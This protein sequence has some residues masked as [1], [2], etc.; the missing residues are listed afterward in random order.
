MRRHGLIAAAGLAVIA[1][2]GTGCRHG[3]GE[4]TGLFARSADP[5]VPVID[6]EVGRPCNTGGIFSVGRKKHHGDIPAD[7]VV[8]P[9]SAGPMYADLPG[10]PVYPSGVPVPFGGSGVGAPNELPAPTISPPGVPEQPI[11]AAVTA[12]NVLPMPSGPPT[13]RPSGSR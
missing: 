13:A 11:P 5:C 3:C 7:T 4:R 12:G 8:L 2:G 10:V 6:R 1:A 9:G